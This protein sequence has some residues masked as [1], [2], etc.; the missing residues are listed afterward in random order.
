MEKIRF[1]ILSTADIARKNWKS[2]HNSGNSI[3]AAIASRDIGRSR[4]FIK[5]LQAEAPFEPLPVALGSYQE[6]LASK[7]IDAVYIPLDTRTAAHSPCGFMAICASNIPLIWRNGCSFQKP[8]Y[9]T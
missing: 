3:V 2:I 5:E 4:R 6:L 8:L 7:N 9:Q 1:G